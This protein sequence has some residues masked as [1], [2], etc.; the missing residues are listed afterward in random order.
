MSYAAALQ[1]VNNIIQLDRMVR[2][3]LHSNHL[4]GWKCLFDFHCSGD[5]MIMEAISRSKETITTQINSN[6]RGW[7]THNCLDPDDYE[8]DEDFD[9]AGQ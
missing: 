3:L 6:V 9:S 8:G 2:R 7:E 1:M 5:M 4:G